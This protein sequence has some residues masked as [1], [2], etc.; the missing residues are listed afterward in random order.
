[1]ELDAYFSYAVRTFWAGAGMRITLLADSCTTGWLNWGHGE[2]W[3]T[4]HHVVRI[5]RR[6]LTLRSA[7][8]GGAMGG[9]VAAAGGLGLLAVQAADKKFASGRPAPG[10]VVEVEKDTW[11]GELDG[12]PKALILGRD[13]IDSLDYRHGISS[14][15]LHIRMTDGRE[16]KLLWLPNPHAG[17]LLA[18]AFGPRMHR[19]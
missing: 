3:L 9:A 14:S 12:Q 13:D 2:L 7:A 18:H 10:A 16:H 5:G 19:S 15:R 11:E 1:M 8:K 6:E 17:N 4:P